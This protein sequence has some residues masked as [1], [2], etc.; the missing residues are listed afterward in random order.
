MQRWTNSTD[1]L[2]WICSSL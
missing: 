2:Y 1:E